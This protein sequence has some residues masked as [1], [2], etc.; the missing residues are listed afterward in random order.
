LFAK[1]STAAADGSNTLIKKSLEQTTQRVSIVFC[2]RE[3]LQIITSQ[4]MISSS[5]QK[6]LRSE[7]TPDAQNPGF[8][9]NYTTDHGD[10]VSHE[11]GFA[12]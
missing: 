2:P 8:E 3:S 12:K 9:R 6:H 7:P 5:V 1:S 10:A 4:L 11:S